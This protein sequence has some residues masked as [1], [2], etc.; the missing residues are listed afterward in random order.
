[1]DEAAHLGH[2]TGVALALDLAEELGGIEHPGRGALAQIR[3]E[4]VDQPATRRPAGRQWMTA[5][6]P[7]APDGLAIMAR[8]AGDFTDRHAVA[9]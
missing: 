7:D 3:C 5:P 4:G 6:R 9:Q 2:P 8:A 1:M